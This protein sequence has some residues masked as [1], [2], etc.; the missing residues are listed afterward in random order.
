[1]DPFQAKSVTHLAHARR[2]TKKILLKLQSDSDGVIKDLDKSVEEK[3]NSKVQALLLLDNF[4]ET[5]LE[6]LERFD[7]ALKNGDERVQNKTRRNFGVSSP[8]TGI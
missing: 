3:G 6:N 1:M 8:Q 7:T 5:A 2:Q 4:K